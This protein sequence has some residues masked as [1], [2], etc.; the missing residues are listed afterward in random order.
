MSRQNPTGLVE[1]DVDPTS[2]RGRSCCD[3]MARASALSRRSLLK[4]LLAGAASVPALGIVSANV[5]YASP[6]D[7][8]WA[9]DTLVVLS[10][11]GGF[12]GLSAIVPMPNALYADYQ[13]LRPRIGIPQNALIGL[14]G[15]YG[16]HPVMQPLK[17]LYDNGKFG[18]VVATGLPAPNRSHFDAMDEMEKAVP[19]SAPRNGWLSRVMGQHAGALKPLSAVQIG[20]SSMPMSYVGSYPAVGIDTLEDFELDGVGTTFT[21]ARWKTAL[22]ALHSSAPQGVKAAASSTLGALDQVATAAAIPSAAS[23]ENNSTARALQDAARLIK[24][25]IGV[26][27]ITLDVGDWDMHSDLGRVDGGWMYGNLRELSRA[28]AAFAD[29]LGTG[30]DNVTLVTLSEFGRRAEEND[31]GGVDHGWG[32]V[33]FV[34]GGH[35]AGIKGSW[36]GLA[37]SNL[38]QGDLRATTDYRAVLAEVL[39]DRCRAAPEDVTA[40]F[41]NYTGDSGKFPGIIAP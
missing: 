38:V 33:M 22:T 10:L 14:D 37:D 25:G 9:G 29:D 15:T 23:Y 34:L 16:M 4:G 30:L 2:A 26:K 11:R 40:V 5:A 8:T 20:S 1:A 7:T 21:A 18:A 36:P 3:E 19:G 27:L 24:S 32:N 12:D 39:T 17:G 6:A 13:R 41:P 35:V 31:S 28:L